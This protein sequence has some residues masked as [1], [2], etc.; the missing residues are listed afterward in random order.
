MHPPLRHT[1]E[2]ASPGWKKHPHPHPRAATPVAL[3]KTVVIYTDTPYD[4][5]KART[6]PTATSC[7][8][9]IAI[10]RPAQLLIV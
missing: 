7:E 3:A 6:F 2:S 1:A 8:S 5:T 4:F 10:S 9:P